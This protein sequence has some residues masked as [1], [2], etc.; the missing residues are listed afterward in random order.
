MPW[1]DPHRQ[2]DILLGDTGVSRCSRRRSI[3]L[4]ALTLSSDLGL[5]L[6][7][8]NAFEPTG[9]DQLLAGLAAGYVLTDDWGSPSRPT[10]PL[11]A[12]QRGR[13]RPHAH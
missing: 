13:R 11:P 7:P 3:E 8:Q 2:R 5:E 10:E 9:A 1:L 4:D 12:G 6:A